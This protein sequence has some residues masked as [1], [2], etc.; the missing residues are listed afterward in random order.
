MSIMLQFIHYFDVK[1]AP[2]YAN[3][4]IWMMISFTKVAKI[5]CYIINI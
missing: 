1:S 5:A 4:K 2:K 3:I